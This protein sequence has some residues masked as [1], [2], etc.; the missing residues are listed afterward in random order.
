MRALAATATSRT[1]QRFVLPDGRTLG[2]AEFGAASGPV[3]FAF[4][5]F[6]ASRLDA[7]LFDRAARQQRVR[8]IAPDR[9]GFGLS[10]F[11]VTRRITDWPADVRALAD[12]LGLQS[13]SVIGVSGGGPY[14]LACAAQL[15]HSMLCGVGVMAG[16]PPMEAAPGVTLPSAVGLHL[17]P[18]HTRVTQVLAEHAPR[19]LSLIVS[20]L[21]GTARWIVSTGLVT[22]RIDAYLERTPPAPV[23]PT[24]SSE[25]TLST[26]KR[27]ERLLAIFFDGFNSGAGGMVHESQLLSRDWGLRFEDLTYDPVHIWHG[28]K[29]V[30]SPI[31]MMR[32]MS[33][34]LPHAQLHEYDATHYSL[35][36]HV[37]E[38]LREIVPLNRT[39]T[40]GSTLEN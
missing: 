36:M 3:V 25:P 30:N 9:P 16:A 17:L 39:A 29:D 37:D 11:Q 31:A 6:P 4:H 10:S 26:V 13:F 34:R 12:H 32:Y 5:G 24:M 20:V 38:I 15:P 19:T 23:D 28:V 22:R 14:A 21:V 8:I 27:R 7:V 35:G 2:Y 18:F 33:R 40:V 1:H